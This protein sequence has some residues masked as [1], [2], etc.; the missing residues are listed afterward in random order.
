MVT[1][2]FYNKDKNSMCRVHTELVLS[3]QDQPERR[4]ENHF[5]LGKSNYNPRRGYLLHI[6]EIKKI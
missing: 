1:N 6:N 2:F 5:A 4:A 3:I